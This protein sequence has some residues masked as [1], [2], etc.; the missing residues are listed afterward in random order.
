MD[1]PQKSS[2][3][4]IWFCLNNRWRFIDFLNFESADM[5]RV[6][7]G[8]VHVRH[9]DKNTQFSS[10]YLISHKKKNRLIY[11]NFIQ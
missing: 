2:W 3:I 4:H 9:I 5:N 11:K 6:L 1:H 7:E 10:I 8:D